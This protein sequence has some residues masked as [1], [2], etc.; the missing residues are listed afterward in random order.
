[1]SYAPLELTGKVAVVVGGTSGIGRILALGL[2]EAGADVIPTARRL[3]LVREVAAEVEARGR[4][5][6][7]VA[8]DVTDPS[9]LLAA[10]EEVL[11]EF[12]RLDILVNCAG[13]IKRQPTLQM[14]DADWSATL[15]VNLTGTLHCCRAFAV[16]MLER[17]WGRIINI[18][19]LTS[20]VGLFEVAAYAASKA[21]V[22]ALTKSLAVEWGPLGV[23]VN[24]IAPG[25]F[26]TELNR[27]LL[28]G[29]ERGKE[30]LL[31][32][33]L[34]RFGRLEEL[35]GAAVFLASEAASFVNGEV[36]VVDG[37]YLA[38]GVNR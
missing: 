15:E 23:N 36:L 31:R 21:G 25:F 30:A 5:T 24:A 6:L 14:S 33:P 12:G 11:S 22:V 29:T 38:S 20:F 28:E 9:S 27:S 8:S 18:A 19:S 10:R 37:G 17:G 32:S 4:R 35:P 2:A 13:R 7:R 16:P 34:R 1:M 26:L 3:E